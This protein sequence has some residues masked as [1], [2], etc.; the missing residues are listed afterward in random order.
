[1]IQASNH[2]RLYTARFYCFY[3]AILVSLKYVGLDKIKLIVYL[4]LVVI[5]IFFIHRGDFI[6]TVIEKEARKSDE[7][8]YML[9]NAE[10]DGEE[11]TDKFI[12]EE[13]RYCLGKFFGGGWDQAD[14]YS[15]D[16]WG[17]GDQ[18][19]TRAEARKEVRILKRFLKKHT[20]SAHYTDC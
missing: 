18:W 19:G 2:G 3:E 12:I 17:G 5:K 16:G 9:E 8:A 20:G 15:G 1:M 10:C 4:C 6:M 11:L 13:A 14:A 7:L